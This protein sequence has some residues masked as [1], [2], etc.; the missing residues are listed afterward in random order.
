MTTASLQ[1][2]RN[3]MSRKDVLPACLGRGDLPWTTDYVPKDEWQKQM[4]AVC[5]ECPVRAEC[6]RHALETAPSGFYA[7]MWV[8]NRGGRQRDRLRRIAEGLSA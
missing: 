7:G 8:S 5:E 1:S 2:I 3:T 6:A 4:A